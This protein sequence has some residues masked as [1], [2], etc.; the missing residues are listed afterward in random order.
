MRD[1]VVAL[2]VALFLAAVPA[3]SASAE[4]LFAS[5]VVGK[6]VCRAKSSTMKVP[7]YLALT[8]PDS[9]RT[10]SERKRA[11]R[12]SVCVQNRLTCRCKRESDFAARH[13]RVFAKWQPHIVELKNVIPSVGPQCRSW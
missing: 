2:V 11:H 13:N 3:G 6:Q 5:L 4:D 7:H 1:V 9:E 8:Y 10:E 12:S